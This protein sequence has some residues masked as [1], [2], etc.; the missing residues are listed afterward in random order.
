MTEKIIIDAED[1]P[2]GRVS[3]FAAKA[4]LQGRDVAVVNSEKAII[5]GNKMTTIA[6]FKRRRAF[7]GTALKGPF[8]SKDTEKI[9]KRCIRGMLPNFRRG[10]GREAWKK[11]KC[12]NGVP[13]EFSKEKLIKIKVRTPLKRIDLKELKQRM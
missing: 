13:K 4:A 1:M 6:R 7:G 3:G 10:R 8:H 9:L 12:Y 11:I 2:M 5:S